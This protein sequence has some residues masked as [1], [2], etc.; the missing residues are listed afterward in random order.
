MNQKR[1]PAARGNPALLVLFG[2]VPA[3]PDSEFCKKSYPDFF[4]L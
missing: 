2:N 4:F 3:L 1:A